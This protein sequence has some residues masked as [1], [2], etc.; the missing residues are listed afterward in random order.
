MD[1]YGESLQLLALIVGLAA[2]LVGAAGRRYPVRA[3]AAML[4]AVAAGLFLLL[5]LGG[6][7]VAL[8]AQLAGMTTLFVAP[9]AVVALLLGAGGATIIMR[10][11]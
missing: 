8:A 5:A 10:K 3:G 4:M 2:L 7:D 11:R 1:G 9:V 6:L